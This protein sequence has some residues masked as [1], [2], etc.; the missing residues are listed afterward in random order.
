MPETTPQT[1]ASHR[2]Y[3][4]IF[5]FFTFGVLAVSFLLTVWRTVRTPSLEN[6]WW[7]VVAA[8]ALVLFFKVRGYAL[9]VQDRV[10]RLEERLRLE[11]LLAEPLKSRVGDLGEG[12]LVG[13][14]FASDG[15]VSDLVKEALDEKLSCEEIKKR[16]KVWRPDTF[17]V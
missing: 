6:A 13:L 3:D 14:R 11:K 15:E 12:Q 1:Y 10:I 16:I 5:H 9:K 17:R 2:R 8:A 4:P 7:I